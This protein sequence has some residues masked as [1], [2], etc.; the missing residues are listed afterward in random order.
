M[1]ST[2]FNYLLESSSVLTLE[3]VLL[4]FATVI[5]LSLCI[6]VSY[7]YTGSKIVYSARFNASLVMLAL[8]TTLVMSCIGNNVA[9][10]LGMVGALSIIRF[11]TAIKDARDAAYIFWAIAVGICCGVS[12]YRIAGI[13][14]LYMFIILLIVGNVQNN[15]RYLL[16]VRAK[17]GNAEKIRE[18]VDTYYAKKAIF[19]ANNSNKE[20]DEI[21]YLVSSGTIKKAKKNAETVSEKLYAMEGVTSV[22]MVSQNN[23]MN[24]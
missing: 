13:G 20:Y 16:V 22:N 17:R 23:E 21:I 18:C 4:N 15:T 19:R 10:S 6:Y 7:K 24:S 9:L 8:I 3:Q 5:V 2:L 14:T 1:K 12:D 11:R